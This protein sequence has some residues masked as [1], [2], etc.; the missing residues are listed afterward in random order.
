[1]VTGLAQS[2]SSELSSPRDNGVKRDLPRST[3]LPQIEKIKIYKGPRGA[4]VYSSVPISTSQLLSAVFK[5][6]CTDPPTIGF[7][8][9][10][11]SQVS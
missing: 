5:L 11:F 9:V 8:T 1:M 2:G 7:T 6:Y 3:E 10:I 4:T